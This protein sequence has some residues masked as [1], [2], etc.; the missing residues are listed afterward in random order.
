MQ[1]EGESPEACPTLSPD[2][3]QNNWEAKVENLTEVE[4]HQ[5]VAKGGRILNNLRCPPPDGFSELHRFELMQEQK[6]IR[7]EH[8]FFHHLEMVCGFDDFTKLPGISE[9]IHMAS[10]S[11]PLGGGTTGE[12]YFL[13]HFDGHV[14]DGVHEH[15][16]F[17]DIGALVI[18]EVF[19]LYAYGGDHPTNKSIEL[20][21]QEPD[22]EEL[23]RHSGRLQWSDMTWLIWNHLSDNYHGQSGAKKP[24]SHVLCYHVV[25][26][27]VREVLKHIFSDKIGNVSFPAPV[28]FSLTNNPVAFKALVASPLVRAIAYMLSQH[29]DTAGKRT[30]ESVTVSFEDEILFLLAMCNMTVKIVDIPV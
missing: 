18:L 8:A 6:W 10:P 17:M 11:T 20:T 13:R 7:A 2:N 25:N 12:F 5:I 29:E 23:G 30:I 15:A 27:E 14:Y 28:T 21:D 16:F 4:Y 22:K 3:N 1:M 9:F 19:S 24:L 26:T